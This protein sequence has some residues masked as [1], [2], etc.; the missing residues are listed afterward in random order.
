MATTRVRTS[1]A[2]PPL[3]RHP[4][5]IVRLHLHLAL[6]RLHPHLLLAVAHTVAAGDFYATIAQAN[7]IS[8]EALFAANL[9]VDSGCTNL[10]IGQTLDLRRRS[11]VSS[12][13]RVPSCVWTFLLFRRAGER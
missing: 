5:A 9:T 13:T 12:M 3:T 2:M 6:T 1:S 7:G 4:L 8:V 10:Q 11:R